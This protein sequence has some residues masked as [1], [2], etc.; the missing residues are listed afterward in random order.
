MFLTFVLLN[1]VNSS[2]FVAHFQSN[3][4]NRNRF[5]F[6][7][8]SVTFVFHKMT[9][10]RGGKSYTAGNSNV[11]LFYQKDNPFS[12]F[13]PAEID[14]EGHHFATSE[15]Y[16][17][18]KKAELFDDQETM[19]KILQTDDPRKAKALGRQIHNFNESFWS[20]Y[21]EEFMLTVNLAKF[22]QHP[23]LR[24]ILLDTGDLILA[25]ASPTDRKWGIGMKATDYGASDPSNWKGQNLLGKVL[26]KV[27]EQLRQGQQQKCSS[28][29]D[30]PALES[31]K[32]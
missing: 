30:M 26:M 31:Q 16:F 21:C 27:R 24:K 6:V 1:W 3:S 8:L 7:S 22:N 4:L 18:F 12:N 17:H 15:H 20:N 19:A 10:L 28:T 13:Y 25:E 29:N 32:H 23:D 5:I 14:A 9:A 2:S 11:C